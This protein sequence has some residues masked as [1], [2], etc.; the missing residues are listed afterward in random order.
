MQTAKSTQNTA[1]RIAIIGGTGLQAM[2]GFE[3]KESIASD[4]KWGEPSVPV[5]RGVL[6]GY[7]VFFM[8]RHGADQVIPPH[9]V[10]Y[11]ANI[12]ALYQLDIDCIL[13]FNAVGGIT[14]GYESGTLVVPDQIIDYTW[15]REQTFWTEKNNELLHAEFSCPYDEHLRNQLL[16]S[17]EGIEAVLKDGGVYGATQGPRLESAAEIIRMERDG[18]DIVGMTGMPEAGLARELN[19][20]Y[21]SLALVVNLA[22]GKSSQLITMGEIEAVMAEG[23]PRAQ[24]ILAATVGQ[25]STG[26][27]PE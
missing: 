4:T 11:R 5:S 22:A 8:P 10:N 9:K 12:A 25:L 6:D 17:G 26:S 2:N 14:Q 19:I 20:P 16:T 23:L 3:L 27:E 15:G 24:Q 18:C 1:R 21:A 7:E 13:A